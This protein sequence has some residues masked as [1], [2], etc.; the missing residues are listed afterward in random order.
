MTAPSP[1][2]C[3]YPANLLRYSPPW[4][5]P[6]HSIVRTW[7]SVQ[8]TPAKSLSRMK[9]TL[10]TKPYFSSHCPVCCSPHTGST[11]TKLAARLNLCRPQNMASLSQLWTFALGIFTSWNPSFTLLIPAYPQGSA[12]SHFW[13]PFLLSD[14]L[15]TTAWT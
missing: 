12:S 1:P 15:L 6:G 4:R 3:L 10:V 7:K 14:G 5:Q 11:L 9:P 2:L 8:G 13:K